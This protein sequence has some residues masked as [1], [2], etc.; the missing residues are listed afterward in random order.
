MSG[1]YLSKKVSNQLLMPCESHR[2]P[3]AEQ[4]RDHCFAELDAYWNLEQE[5][6]KVVALPV[7]TRLYYP[8]YC[9]AMISAKPLC[10]F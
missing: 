4:F 5:S 3:Q 7:Q 9:L 1:F 2:V 6:A 8:K 10:M